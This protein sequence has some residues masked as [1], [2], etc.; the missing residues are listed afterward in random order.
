MKALLLSHKFHDKIIMEHEGLNSDDPILSPFYKYQ[1]NI[2][3]YE[4][5]KKTNSFFPF[6]LENYTC[7]IFHLFFIYLL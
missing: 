7:K 2:T 6:S 4:E 3:A 1:F 5:G